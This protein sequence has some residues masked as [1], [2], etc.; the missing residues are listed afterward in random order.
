MLRIDDIQRQAVDD[1]H[2]LGVIWR[3]VLEIFTI[4]CYNKIKKGGG[5]MK[6]E[7]K[8]ILTRESCKAEL[9]RLSK[10]NLVQDSVILAVLL[11]IFVPLFALSIYLA[12][13]ILLLG[14]VF[15]LICAIFPVLFIGRIIRDVMFSRTVEQ[16]GFSIVKDTVSRISRDEIPKS[17]SEGRRT[18][19]VIYFAKYGR[20]VAPKV[21]T[22][23]DLS[24]VGDEFYLVIS[25]KKDEIIF[26]YNSVM[27]E[28]KEL[29]DVI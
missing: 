27:Y 8:N 23:F 20:C 28:C 26:A 10:A 1:I 16:D 6:K 2:A 19:N 5:E 9:K 14:I 3:E 17:Y 13:Y 12:K 15:A 18:V 7:S 29:D 24:G 21:R 4:L 22:P 25:H 11:L